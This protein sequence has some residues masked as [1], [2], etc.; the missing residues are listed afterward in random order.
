MSTKTKVQ[1]FVD[2]VNNSRVSTGDRRLRRFIGD[3][4]DRVRTPSIEQVARFNTL[5]DPILSEDLRAVKRYLLEHRLLHKARKNARSDAFDLNE[6]ETALSYVVS[7][8]T[9]RI[10]VNKLISNY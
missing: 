6:L 2:A 4:L 8:D 1:R 7:N 9:H 5:I 3:S 10:Q